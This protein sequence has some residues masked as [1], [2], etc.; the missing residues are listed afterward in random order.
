M[1]IPVETPNEPAA[2]AMRDFL[3]IIPTEDMS[4]VASPDGTEKVAVLAGV[5]PGFMTTQEIADL[6]AGGSASIPAG[7]PS[8]L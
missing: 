1:A 7:G 2:A 5:L 6:G 8:S 3:G 4:A